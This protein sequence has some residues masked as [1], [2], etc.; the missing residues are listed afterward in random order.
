MSCDCSRL[1]FEATLLGAAM[2]TCLILGVLG[3]FL[4]VCLNVAGRAWKVLSGAILRQ[5]G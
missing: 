4:A 1:Y 2:A 5:V 3:V